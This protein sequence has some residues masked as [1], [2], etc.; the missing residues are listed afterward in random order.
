LHDLPDDAVVDLGVGV[1]KNV[2]EGN[3]VAE[4]GDLGRESESILASWAS[5][6]PMTA[7]ARSTAK[8]SIGFRWY[9]AKSLPSV[10]WAAS[11]AAS[12]MS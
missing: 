3:D 2:T 5:A 11:L 9:S 7:K 4:V 8:R 10:N 6:S 1:D 12:W